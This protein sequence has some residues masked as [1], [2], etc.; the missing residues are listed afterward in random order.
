M[1]KLCRGR[2][3]RKA[4]QQTQK[5]NLN[6]SG[7][8]FSSLTSQNM[9]PDSQVV[10]SYKH[11]NIEKDNP[12]ENANKNSK[13]IACMEESKKRL[14]LVFEEQDEN[15]DNADSLEIGIQCNHLEQE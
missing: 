10:E 12:L 7:D 1:S 5:T 13:Q 9:L 6:D 14:S 2:S 8:E 11:D 15:F 4:T 3:R